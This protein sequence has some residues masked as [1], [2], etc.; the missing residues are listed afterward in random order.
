MTAHATKKSPNKQS[1]AWI[2]I[3]G[4][5]LGVIVVKQGNPI[6]LYKYTTQTEPRELLE[7]IY[8]SWPTKVGFLLTLVAGLIALWCTQKI[9][10]PLTAQLILPISWLAWQTIVTLVTNEAKTPA[11]VLLHFACELAW[12]Y[13][14]VLAIRPH[15]EKWI[16]WAGLVCGLGIII[17]FGFDQRFG[18]LEQTRK[19]FWEHIYPT[20][21]NPDPELIKRMYSN[22]IFSTLFYPNTLAS[23]LIL[24]TP[25]VLWSIWNMESIFKKDARVLLIIVFS[26][27]A[28]LCLVWSGSKAGWIIAL[29]QLTIAGY[30]LPVNPQLKRIFLILVLLAGMIGFLCR[31]HA[32]LQK[33]APSAEARLYYWKAALKLTAQ[34]PLFGIG[35]GNFGRYYAKIKPPEAEMAKLVHNDYLQQAVE[36]GIPGFIL[37]LSAVGVCMLNAT[38]QA[39][40]SPYS[41]VFCL[42]L[43]LIGWALQSFTEF[44]LYIP[45]V[46]WIAFCFLGCLAIP[47]NETHGR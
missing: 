21:P 37:F 24:C 31:Y 26:A 11:I 16:P 14:G 33:G 47:V 10:K 2:F 4:L 34:N 3:I 27:G 20:L 22:R 13:I 19:F 46:G 9:P 41:A 25:I 38:R 45:A 36:S 18:G 17:L 6:I 7:W 28:F 39:I 44:G 1:V 29:C 23:V 15:L 43:G 8:M 40:R 32:Y 42:W 12:F 5:I 30:F 35:Q